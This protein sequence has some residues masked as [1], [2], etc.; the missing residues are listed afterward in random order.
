MDKELKQWLVVA[1]TEAISNDDPSHD[2][3]H[4]LRVLA[5]A[6]HLA[7]REGGDLDVIVPAALFHFLNC[8][9]HEPQ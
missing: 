1:A 6:E 4:A 7:A 2:L 3:I 9:G 5:L 8:R